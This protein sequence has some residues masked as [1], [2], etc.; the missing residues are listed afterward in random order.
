MAKHIVIIGG[1]PA[2]YEAALRA[3]HAGAE[4]TLIEAHKIGGTCLNYGCIP[5]KTLVEH[6]TFYRK[7]REAETM[8]LLVADLTVDFEKINVHKM[9]VVDS[10]Q[11]GILS[12]L[13]KAKVNHLHGTGEIIKAGLVKVTIDGKETSISCD[14]IILATG[15]KAI[16]PTFIGENNQHLVTSK[17]LLEMSVYPDEIVIVGGGVIGMEFAFILNDFG[18]KV[19]V[20]EYASNLLPSIDTAISKRLKSLCSKRGIRVETGAKVTAITNDQI[21][22]ETKK[23]MQ[24]IMSPCTLIALGR[25][26]Y[27]NQLMC[28]KI[29]LE[30][31]KQFIKV[32]NCYE[33]SIEHI[34][35]IGDVNGHS[36]LAHSAYDQARQLIDYLMKGRTIKKKLIPTCIFV[37]PEIACVGMTEEEVK[38]QGIDYLTKK[39]LYGSSGKAMAMNEITGFVKTIVDT[40]GYL[41]GLHVLGAHASD[42]VHYGS[43]AI[44]GKM[45]I[46][47]LQEIIFA[48]PTIGE[49]FSDNLNHY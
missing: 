15:S 25:Q 38:E 21:T 49:L 37:T 30:H 36:L 17:D 35:A 12:Q 43:I 1:G 39:T 22:Y 48:H 5:T 6:A 31:T 46:S 3:G 45:T 29:G 27:Y 10:L 2:G 42:L 8:G 44:Q 20:L 13:K 32:S 19:T 24:T 18:T 11:K 41:I 33:T 26:G 47:D 28:D 9:N 23:G 16:M 7:V 14:E 34:Y 40:E 4:V